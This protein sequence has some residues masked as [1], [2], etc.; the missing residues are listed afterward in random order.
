MI[1]HRLRWERHDDSTALT[2]TIQLSDASG[3]RLLRHLAFRLH[4]LTG[5]SCD[6]SLASLAEASSRQLHVSAKSRSE[7]LSP[8]VIAVGS[9]PETSKLATNLG[10]FETSEGWVRLKG[11][12]HDTWRKTD[13]V[14]CLD[15]VSATAAARGVET[16]QIY[17]FGMGDGA[18]IALR[19]LAFQPSAFG[20]V[21]I[22]DGSH[23]DLQQLFA[24]AIRLTH[25]AFLAAS[26]GA[27]SLCRMLELGRFLHATGMH[28]TTK[29]SAGR[30]LDDRLPVTKLRDFVNWT[31]QPIP[32]ADSSPRRLS[33]DRIP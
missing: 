10:G 27:S 31:R 22:F 6:P 1:P 8:L 23:P 20:G 28:V 9:E 5:R 16:R 30:G 17:L 25:R 7:E 3:N 32:G 14:K 11:P 13:L 19:L 4:Y 24:P 12:G 15:I 2:R 29:L 18:A 21:G 33:R 26:T